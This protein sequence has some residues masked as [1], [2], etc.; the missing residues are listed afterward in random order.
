MT[1]TRWYDK[2]N[3]IKLLMEALSH[4][5]DDVKVHVAA[6]LIQMA[7]NKR[8]HK[9]DELIEEINQEYHPVRRR[10]YDKDETLHSAIELLKY[11]DSDEKK[12]FFKEILYSIIYFNDEKEFQK[13]EEM[14][15]DEDSSWD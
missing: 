12:E 2:D 7:M 14:T 9:A 4:L 5:D 11:I 6:D 8:G 10:W 3:Q 15:E 13:Y 1:F